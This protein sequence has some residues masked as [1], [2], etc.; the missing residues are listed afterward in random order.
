MTALTL[1]PPTPEGRQT[2]EKRLSTW[3]SLCDDFNAHPASR[4]LPGD[5][6]Y[7]T[8]ETDQDALSDFCSA[9]ERLLMI[10][11]APD[12][13]ALLEK[14]DIWWETQGPHRDDANDTFAVIRADVE[15]LTKNKGT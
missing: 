1:V 8:L 14:M 7:D 12:A 11:P 4:M 5:P 2:W 3:R 6:E 13:A 15:R 9:G 10:T